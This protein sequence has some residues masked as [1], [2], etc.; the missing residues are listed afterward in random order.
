MKRSLL[1]LTLCAFLTP[2]LAQNPRKLGNGTLLV[3]HYTSTDCAGTLTSLLE[4]DDQG[5]TCWDTTLAT[6]LVWDGAAWTTVGSGGSGDMAKSVYDADGDGT[7]D[8]A[9]SAVSSSALQ[10]AD[11][12]T[13]DPD[14]DDD[15]TAQLMVAPV[16]RH[17]DRELKAHGYDY[18]SAPDPPLAWYHY[19]WPEFQLW[20][21]RRPDWLRPVFAFA[22]DMPDYSENPG[23]AEAC[24]HALPINDPNSCWNYPHHGFETEH[25]GAWPLGN[26][27]AALR[28]MSNTGTQAGHPMIDNYA[29]LSLESYRPDKYG[30]RNR[31]TSSLWN[32]DNY[33][34]QN[35]FV[36]RMQGDYNNDGTLDRSDFGYPDI[37][38]DG[39]GPQARGI[40]TGDDM[41]HDQWST[42]RLIQM[43]DSTNENP[44]DPSAR[45]GM[46][47]AA[48]FT[49]NFKDVAPCTTNG[50]V[51]AGMTT[52]FHPQQQT[53]FKLYPDWQ[54]CGKYLQ[55]G[56][57]WPNDTDPYDNTQFAIQTIEYN[58]PESVE[59][60]G[61]WTNLQAYT[62]CLGAIPRKDAA[63]E[64]EGRWNFD[65]EDG[66]VP[67]SGAVTFDD[68][69]R[70]LTELPADEVDLV[71]R[72]VQVGPIV[73]LGG[74]SDLGPTWGAPYLA[75]DLASVDPEGDGSYR[76]TPSL[77]PGYR[78]DADGGLDYSGASWWAVETWSGS[79]PYDY[80]GLGKP[81]HQTG[82]N[83]G[84][85]AWDDLNGNNLID[86]DEKGRVDNGNGRLRQL[87]PGW[88]GGIEQWADPT[89]KFSAFAAL[90]GTDL[91]WVLDFDNSAS[92]TA[93]DACVLNNGLDANCD[94]SV[95][96]ADFPKVDPDT[97]LDP[98]SGN[99]P[100]DGDLLTYTTNAGLG[101]GG[102]EFLWKTGDEA[103]LLTKAGYDSND[104]GYVD[105]AASAQIASGLDLTADGSGDVTSDGTAVRFDVNGAVGCDVAILPSGMDADCDG[106]VD[107]GQMAD[108]T[109]WVG[110]GSD[111]SVK[112]LPDCD[113][114][115]STLQYDQSSNAFSCGDDDNS[116]GAPGGSSTYAQYNN[117]GAFAGTA[118]LTI[119]PS[120]GAIT[121]TMAPVA[122]CAWGTTATGKAQGDMCID[123]TSEQLMCV[124]QDGAWYGCQY[125]FGGTGAVPFAGANYE[126][127]QDGTAF[128]YNK[129]TN[130]LTV[131]QLTLADSAVTL[132]SETTGNYVSSATASQGLTLTGTE[133]ASLGLMDCAAN[134]ILK[135]NSGDTAW[136]C[137][138][139]GGGGAL[140]LTKSIEAP[141][142][143]ENLTLGYFAS[144][145]TIDEVTCVVRD[146][147]SVTIQ[148][149]F[150]TQ[151]SAAGTSVLSASL[152][153]DT[154]EGATTTSF[155]D[156]SVDATSWLWFKSSAISGVPTELA[157]TVRYH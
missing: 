148:L 38:F 27:T 50:C 29:G 156:A 71:R 94:C 121:R 114:D 37:D 79:D 74:D 138:A 155:A 55:E 124:A 133:G 102:G 1:L 119:D 16:D 48:Q 23:E 26:S 98:C 78:V 35:K 46:Q 134:Q 89:T 15:D 62:L 65:M 44:N 17:E 2:A 21:P 118:R 154:A 82:F 40:W 157:I 63:Q 9:A 145:A 73:T 93:A 66:Q 3:Q 42:L 54:N 152:V 142:S 112:T 144:A 10:G 107:G 13:I 92:V 122:S 52:R 83:F 95:D 108:D 105:W 61:G 60:A 57:S 5:V 141:T 85:Y 41:S 106:T 19:P 75:G 109:I 77:A 149:Y 97:S 131:D 30:T 153:C 137:A 49:L 86:P 6:L 56:G 126:F 51:S 104:D 53:T 117:A 32:V 151:R 12:V 103:G 91:Q 8:A 31:S 20:N 130:T 116:G 47:H 143:S 25:E 36:V 87:Q 33:D 72:R 14:M 4:A 90:C 43:Y 139:D 146:G 125:L 81:T 128:V 150:A 64:I 140:L 127:D 7:V 69:F 99:V 18:D 96:T 34:R 24:S 39:S 100:E 129:S 110:T 123:S 84:I 80:E 70:A 22:L 136:E 132:G 147:T 68:G 113:G 76:F 115:G 67:G 11:V 101:C 135:R 88:W 59:E 111:S 45:P 58:S 28:I 120:G